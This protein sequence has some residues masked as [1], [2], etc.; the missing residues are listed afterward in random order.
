MTS[1]TTGPK[2]FTPEETERIQAFLDDGVPYSEI[3]RTMHVGEKRL[4]DAFPGYQTPP[5][6]RG[7]FAA[8]ARQL[9]KIPDRITPKDGR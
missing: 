1:G 4:K 5:Q 2:P 9:N 8:F 3:V 7:T 6:M